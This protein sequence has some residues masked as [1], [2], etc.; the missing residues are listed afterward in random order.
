MNKL[1]TLNI[2]LNKRFLY[3]LNKSKKLIA[4]LN[5]LIFS[6]EKLSL[7]LGLNINIE[8]A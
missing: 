5:I 7:A 2:Y 4:A 8:A 1:L 3:N 6:F